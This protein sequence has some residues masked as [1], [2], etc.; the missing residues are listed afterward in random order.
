MTGTYS[1]AICEPDDQ[2]YGND[3]HEVAPLGPVRYVFHRVL[4]TRG[5]Y[6]IGNDTTICVDGC[7]QTIKVWRYAE[8]GLVEGFSPICVVINRNKSVLA[9]K[10]H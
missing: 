8:D 2:V 10:K 3:P 7:I 5:I 6:H 9:T 4:A 1:D